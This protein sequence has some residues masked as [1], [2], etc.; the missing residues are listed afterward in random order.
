MFVLGKL[1]QFS[2][3]TYNEDKMK[4][5]GQEVLFRDQVIFFQRKTSPMWSGS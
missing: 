2:Q 4:L 1:D 3:D 5:L